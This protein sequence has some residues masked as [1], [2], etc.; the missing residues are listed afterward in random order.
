[1]SAENLPFFKFIT[2]IIDSGIW[3]RLSPAAR[4]LYP[5]LLKFTDGS[6]KPVYP[7]T[8]RLLELTGFK[9]KSTIQKARQEL[10]EEG[11]IAVRRGSGRTNTHYIFRFD[12]V[13]PQ[14]YS[15]AHPTGVTTQPS[16]APM[17]APH[18]VTRDS[19]YN[20]IHISINNH[21]EK[22]DQSLKDRF[23]EE[24]VKYA[25]NECRLA[26]LP[27][28][29]SELEKILSRSHG[30]NA[31]AWT[32]ILDQLQGKIS[33]GSYRLIEASYCGQEDGY[34]ILADRLP[35]FLKRILM[36]ISQNILFEPEFMTETSNRIMRAE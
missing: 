9:Q 32:E 7:G 8:K 3:A 18:G 27:E 34:I 12:T 14:G 10:V 2:S 26:G 29:Y 30:S 35:E 11:L 19:A 23:G 24:A 1:M 31:M 5:V 28:T 13:T 36:N 4:T 22:E 16:A 21:P 20:Q 17:G 15:S 6:F 25:R 33:P